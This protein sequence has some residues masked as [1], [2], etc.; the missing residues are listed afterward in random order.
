MVGGTPRRSARISHLDGGISLPGAH[1]DFYGQNSLLG[2][3]RGGSK[4]PISE[5]ENDR[6]NNELYNEMFSLSRGIGQNKL[7]QQDTSPL[8]TAMAN[9]RNSSR[10]NKGSRETS[11]SDEATPSD[12][13]IFIPPVNQRDPVSSYRPFS[14]EDPWK[15]RNEVGNRNLYTAGVQNPHQT[16]YNRKNHPSEPNSLASKWGMAG[17]RP[18]PA[19]L[20]TRSFVHEDHLFNAANIQSPSIRPPP[21]GRQQSSKNQGTTETSPPPPPPP[22]PPA[23]PAQP[24]PPAPPA[25]PV[26]PA[27]PVQPVPPVQNPPPPPP[28]VPPVQNPPPPPP[29]V[30]PARVQALRDR[31]GKNPEREHSAP[32]PWVTR[33]DLSDAQKD[34]VERFRSRVRLTEG[35]VVPSPPWKKAS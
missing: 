4:G 14:Q 23:P 22:A 32:K 15:L 1:N 13:D 8:D 19:P 33:D 35:P 21:A 25:Q 18:T 10:R 16:P 30:D 27:P 17:G 20:S 28:P 11:L 2:P 3:T 12:D 24:I 29:V 5:D 6:R 26:A 7:P 34:H 31:L 9:I